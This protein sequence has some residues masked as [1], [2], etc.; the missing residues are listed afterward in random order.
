MYSPGL[1]KVCFGFFSSELLF[2]PDPGS[3]KSHLKEV[4]FSEVFEKPT[5]AGPVT[6]LLSIVKRARGG[7]AAS[8]TTTS[9]E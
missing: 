1:S 7:F 4:A 8:V 2:T 5:V 3:P 6:E 9:A